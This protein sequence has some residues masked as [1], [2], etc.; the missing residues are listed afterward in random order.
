MADWT[1]CKLSAIGLKSELERFRAKTYR[2]DPDATMEN[3]SQKFSIQL[4]LIVPM[5][6]DIETADANIQRKWRAENW[7][8]KWD[9]CHRESGPIVHHPRDRDQCSLTCIFDT[10]LSPPLPVIWKLI[11]DWP[12][13]DFRFTYIV[14]GGCDDN[15]A[16][17]TTTNKHAFP[18]RRHHN[19]NL[20]D[21][22]DV[23]AT[24]Q[25]IREF[26]YLPL[27]IR[28]QFTEL[29]IGTLYGSE[30]YGH[31]TEA[32]DLN[33]LATPSSRAADWEARW[34]KWREKP[35]TEQMEWYES[36]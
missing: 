2:V 10:V 13:L 29:Q 15:G 11:N 26:G 8:T 12:D 30:R 33:G 16:V 4:D 28:D 6:I 35:I 5:P 27:Q 7:H 25:R 17:I 14:E 24:L 1:N 18:G 34:R 31:V 36:N 19:F 22:D 20:I 32:Y 3:A 23:D 9:T 21:D